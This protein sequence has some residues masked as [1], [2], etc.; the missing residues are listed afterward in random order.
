MELQKIKEWKKVDEEIDKEIDEVLEGIKRWK[1][2][3][4]NTTKLIDDSDKLI[5]NLT[6]NVDKVN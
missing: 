3:L 5:N 6:Q 4:G 2:T 1:E